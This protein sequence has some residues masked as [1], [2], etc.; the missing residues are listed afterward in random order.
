M[1][2]RLLVHVG[3]RCLAG[4]VQRDDQLGGAPTA[5]LVG[6][7]AVAGLDEAHGIVG[8]QR[9]QQTCDPGEICGNDVGISAADTLS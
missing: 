2:C 9:D 6:R 8:E 5:T 7:A 1:P 3:R 4:A